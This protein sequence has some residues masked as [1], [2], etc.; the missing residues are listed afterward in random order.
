VSSHEQLS[1]ITVLD[2]ST[3]GPAARCTSLL[4]DLGAE[5]VKVL[6]PRDRDRVEP[7]FFA[8]GAGRG[9]R[10]IR[11]DLRTEPG[12]GVFLR[13]ARGADVVVE[14]Y[15]PGVADRLGIGYEACRKE[16][17][18]VVYAAVSGY[19]ADGPYATWA[20]HDLD[21]LAIGGFLAT[22]G[23]RADG[24]PAL[25][26][27]T[28]A[29]SAGGGM[30]AALAITAALLRRTRTGEGAFLDVSTTDGVLWLM[31]LFVDEYL[32]TGQ[33]AGPGADLLTGRYACYDVYAARDDRWLAVGAIEPKFFANLCRALGREDLA[34]HQYED[35]RQDEIRAALRQAF[36]TRDREQWVDELAPK[37]T[38]VA[39]VLSISEVAAD[40][41]LRARSAFA[42]GKHPE[43]GSFEQVAPVMAGSDRGDRLG[44]LPQDGATDVMALL[45]GA[46]LDPQ[47]IDQLMADGVVA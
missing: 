27:A 10:R 15:R 42:Q 33:E 41:H 16:S 19:G 40:A 28:V 21:Y 37:D 12:P 32:A 24:G 14:S 17:A 8:Y 25:P 23:R 4:R 44:E 22:Q 38:C 9:M 11:I 5:V 18:A 46:G 34:S 36:A 45:M 13:L 3:V 30:H 35:G 6:P 7:G 31:S 26:G 1:G 29:D 20:G 43:H 39:P 47:E 2:L